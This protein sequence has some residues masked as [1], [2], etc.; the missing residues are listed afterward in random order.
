MELLRLLCSSD[1]DRSQ[2]N[3]IPAS[4]RQRVDVL[5]GAARD[6]LGE[7]ENGPKAAFSAVMKIYGS[8]GGLRRLPARTTSTAAAGGGGGESRAGSGGAAA[9][10][11]SNGSAARGSKVSKPDGGGGGSPTSS[12]RRNGAAGPPARVR[13]Y[14]KRVLNTRWSEEARRCA[15]V[16]RFVTL[17]QRVAILLGASTGKSSPNPVV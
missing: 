13:G 8:G 2:A 15:L 9:V 1:S 17:K 3:S 7:G 6:K 14:D 4:T 11:A 5:V 16:A 12:S 10:T